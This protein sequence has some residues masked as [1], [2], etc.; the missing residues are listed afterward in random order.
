[1]NIELAGRLLRKFALCDRCL[2]RLFAFSSPGSERSET[3][4]KL[5][6]ALFD[7]AV[8]CYDVELLEALAKSG[9]DGAR[10]TLEE[11][12]TR[13]EKLRCAV[14]KHNLEDDVLTSQVRRAV[15]IASGYEYE[16]FLIGTYVPPHVRRIEEHLIAEY[17]LREAESVRRDVTRQLK[18]AFAEL[19]GKRAVVTNPELAVLI[20][21]F[22][23]TVDVR[24]MPVFVRGRYLKRSRTTPQTPWLC[25]TCW[26]EGCDRC[27]NTGRRRG[28]E[29]S[30]AEY[31]GLPALEI[32]GAIDYKFH[33]AGRED[34][35]ATVE[36]TGRPFVLELLEPR[37][38]RGDLRLYA[39]RVRE[40]SGNRVEVLDLGYASRSEVR[41]LKTEIEKKTKSYRVRVTFLDS[42]SPE[43][44]DRACSVLRGS[45]VSQRTPT[46]V[47]RRKGEKLRHKRVHDVSAVRLDDR[48]YEFTFVVDGGT[49]VKELVHGDSGR[50]SPSVYEC[51]GIEPVSIELTVLGVQ[52]PLKRE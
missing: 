17:G 15:E 9:H 33:A 45:I 25:D 3:G 31:V 12:G 7:E 39:E 43:A 27:D 1:M 35:D 44:I 10:S 13:V 20:D 16:T 11:R 23:G 38:R 29:T 41:F 2:G 34:V 8:K 26:G 19:T 18:K 40:F 48:T 47:L 21:P 49:Y 24:P 14:C 36:G 37:R 6:E 52:Y 51:I 4:R 42:V 22:T 30:I 32:W 28:V 46:R 5:K 50:T